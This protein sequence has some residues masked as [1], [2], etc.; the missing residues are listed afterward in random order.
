M[1][2]LL[3]LDALPDLA[4]TFALDPDS[5]RFDTYTAPHQ[6][7]PDLWLDYQRAAET[8]AASVAHDA[9]KLAKVVSAS[10]QG[11]AQA[12]VTELGARAFRRPLTDQE[13]A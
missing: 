11:N 3:A 6:L 8:V 13:S 12:F 4:K 2:D 7:S 9:A 1:R 10:A 5:S